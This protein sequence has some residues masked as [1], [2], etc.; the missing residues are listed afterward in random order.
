VDVLRVVAQLR[1]EA[2]EAIAEAT[3]GNACRL[4]RIDA[5]PPAEAAA[6]V[7]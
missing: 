3:F 4:F 5:P 7:A 6:P 1:D 2:P